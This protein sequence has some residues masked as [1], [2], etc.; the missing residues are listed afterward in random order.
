M[1][2]ERKNVK[3]GGKEKE[4]EKEKREKGKKD[5]LMKMTL[6]KKLSKTESRELCLIRR[7]K[8]RKKRKKKKKRKKRKNKP[9]ELS[10]C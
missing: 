5:F 7:R 4:K 1:E 3:N 6:S 9:G 8:K 2:G 10:N